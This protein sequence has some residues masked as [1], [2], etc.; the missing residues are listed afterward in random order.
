MLGL[1]F[2]W[3]EFLLY[4]LA[5]ITIF[6]IIETRHNPAAS[7]SWIWAIISF[8]LIAIP[9]YWFAGG[10]RV[11]GF[12]PR[13]GK[14]PKAQNSFLK[15][16]RVDSKYE[17]FE[18]VFS[19]FGSVYTPSLGSAELLID[20]ESTFNA[21]FSAIDQAEKFLIVQYYILRSDRIGRALRMRLMAKARQ[22]VKVYLLIDQI[23]SLGLKNEFLFGLTNSGVE[24]AHFL[25]IANLSRLFF[26]N[27]RNHRKL[28]IIDG[29]IAF[30]GGLN[31]GAEYAPKDPKTWRDTHLRVEGPV[32]KK[33]LEVFCEDWL[34]ATGKKLDFSVGEQSLKKSNYIKMQVVPTGPYDQ[35]NIGGMVFS[36]IIQS[37]KSRLWVSTPFFIPDEQ[38]QRDLEIAV[39]RGV[40]VRLLIPRKTQKRF[41]HMVTLSYAE[42]MQRRGVKVYLYEPG[43]L[44][45]KIV[46]IDDDVASIST[47]N[48]DNRAMYLNFE[49]N[50][51]VLDLEFAS[52]V[53]KNL[54]LDLESSSIF[55]PQARRIRKLV[56]LRDNG[57]RILAPLL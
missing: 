51:L 28:V 30:S 13:W 54:L 56:K 27:N 39:L 21:I 57:A 35:N 49:T 20:G 32:V 42:Q 4:T 10:K 55:E 8:P 14:A 1:D 3:P 15:L 47:S 43:F 16:N 6:R 34:F 38:L 2:G 22:G 9:I 29:M 52:Q 36:V 17:L 46:L 41:V 45:Q 24:F 48:F 37:A 11:K 12:S 31:M 33:L 19:H 7:V 53:E 40:D 50:I 23:G 26:M 44:H 25:P 5:A 18:Q